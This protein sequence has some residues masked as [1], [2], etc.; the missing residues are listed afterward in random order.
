MNITKTTSQTSLL[1]VTIKYLEP[2]LE[3]FPEYAN[4]EQF[5]RRNIS[6][7]AE[8]VYIVGFAV[9]NNQANKRL[10]KILKQGAAPLPG[11]PMIDDTI[12]IATENAE[13]VEQCAG[14]KQ[15]V[16][17]LTNVVNDLQCKYQELQHR[18]SLKTEEGIIN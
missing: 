13:L 15:A 10:Y 14:L 2:V 18:I 11:T 12:I 16:V 3:K 17:H 6:S 4:R 7:F 1:L 8:D 5:N 9:I